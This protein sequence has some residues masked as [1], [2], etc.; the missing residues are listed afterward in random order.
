MAFPSS[1]PNAKFRFPFSDQGKVFFPFE[2]E[3]VG[4]RALLRPSMEEENFQSAIASVPSLLPQLL[5]PV[6]MGPTSFGLL[7]G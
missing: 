4:R 3:D 6:E 1:F 5:Q 2:G 7:A